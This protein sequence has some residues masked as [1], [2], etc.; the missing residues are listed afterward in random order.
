MEI[1]ESNI[2]YQNTVIHLPYYAISVNL[3]QHHGTAQRPMKMNDKL[4]TDQKADENR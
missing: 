3:I 2:T 1:S 4:Y